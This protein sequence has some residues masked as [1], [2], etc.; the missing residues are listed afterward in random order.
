M[1][2]TKIIALVITGCLLISTLTGCFNN[3][4]KSDANERDKSSTSDP[5]D[6]ET[7]NGD[8]GGDGDE[9]PNVEQL[10]YSEGLTFELDTNSDTY[11]VKDLGSCRDT[12]LVI[13]PFHD[14]KAVT[15]IGENFYRSHLTYPD[16]PNIQKVIVPEG[17]HTIED[18]AFK[19]CSSLKEVKLPSSILEIG[20]EAFT[21][22]SSLETITISTPNEV[23]RTIDGVLYSNH[24]KTL[25]HYPAGRKDTTF[26]VP[27]GIEIIDYDAFD[28][29]IYLEHIA[30]P[31][32][33]VKL[34]NASFAHCINL[35]R[36]EIPAGINQI[37]WE[38]FYGCKN[39]TIKYGG[40]KNKWQA[41]N[42]DSNWNNGADIAYI[43]CDDGELS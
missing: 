34:N 5:T 33:I 7:E 37:S 9:Q 23:Y 20:F 28:G 32:T 21:N 8:T 35:R 42:K 27:V 19:G 4:D 43:I 39:L 6:K 12:T 3:N 25:K 24:G 41:I 16:V 22:C 14:G 18:R 11:I 10:E 31:D 36:V 17:I 38:V 15:I 30:L 26:T 29:C 40:T 1:R 13:P 2:L